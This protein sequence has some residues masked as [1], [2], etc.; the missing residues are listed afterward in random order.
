MFL[1]RSAR[2][3]DLDELY[4]LST[5]VQFINLPADRD[6][7]KKKL[8]TSEKS[9]KNPSKNL[10]ENYYFFVLENL[11]TNKLAGASM[12][13]AQHGTPEGPHF[14]LKV[15]Q[16]HKFSQTLNTGFIHGTLKF[17][18]ETNGPTEIGGLVLDPE[19]RGHPDKLGKQISFVRFLYIGI[20][21]DQFRPEIHSELMPPL[22]ADGNSPL[23]EAIGR[24]FLNMDYH[25]ADRLSR[26]NKEFITTLY[27]TDTIYQT[28]LPAIARDAI[29]KVGDETLPVKKMLEKIGF[30]YTQEV[31]P[32]DGGPHYRAKQED[33]LPLKKLRQAPLSFRAS[34]NNLLP[35]I[36]SIPAEKDDFRAILVYGFWEDDKFHLTSEDKANFEKYNLNIPEGFIST[37]IPF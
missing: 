9:F 29:G 10:A 18:I 32:F 35:H 6:L 30:Q 5:L 16:E 21:P 31:D 20:H 36:L 12:I 34:K 33:I 25:E 3:S 1:L 22:D 19:L 13:H 7:I 27:P 28:L 8:A 37:V 26:N 15:G 4:R 14:Y 23:W 24:R 11:T 17:G 2:T